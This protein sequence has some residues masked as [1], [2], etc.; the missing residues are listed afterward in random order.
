VWCKCVAVCCSV[1]QVCCSVLQ[2]V[3]V[4][5]K[6]VAVSCSVLQ[7]CC[8]VSQC[9]AVC[10]K[11]IAV[12]CCS[13]LQSVQCATINTTVPTPLPQPMRA[14]LQKS[15]SLMR[16]YTVHLWK[17]AALLRKY[18]AP[19]QNIHTTGLSIEISC[20]NMSLCNM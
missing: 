11:C 4:Y 17:H 6:C 16:I 10:C 8:S 5:C 7:V 3:A 15:T 9:G 12:C 1:L 13:V 18:T 2:C 14:S 20:R 19:L